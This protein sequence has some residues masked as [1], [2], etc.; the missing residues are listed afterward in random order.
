M[1]AERRVAGHGRRGHKDLITRTGARPPVGYL[2]RVGVIPGQGFVVPDGS[3]R[4]VLERYRRNLETERGL[5]AQTVERYVGRAVRFAAALERNGAI[6]RLTRPS[7]GRHAFPPGQL[8]GAA[9]RPRP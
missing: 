6:G 9:R 8:S 1:S 5:T 7:P 3:A 2:I 4:T